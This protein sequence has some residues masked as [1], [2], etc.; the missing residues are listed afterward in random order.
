M[1]S[2]TKIMPNDFELAVASRFP[3]HIDEFRETYAY[4]L[5]LKEILGNE[6]DAFAMAYEQ[7]RGKLVK[8]LGEEAA[9][10]QIDD[11]IKNFQKR[12]LG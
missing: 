1:G 12:R 9:C 11:N 6:E 5:T 7:I 10:R 4:F 2:H 8:R 3:L